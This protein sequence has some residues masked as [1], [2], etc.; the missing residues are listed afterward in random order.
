MASL[1]DSQ[2]AEVCDARLSLLPLRS[3]RKASVSTPSGNTCFVLH[4][5]PPD[6]IFE[7]MQA[8][9]SSADDDQKRMMEERVILTDYND[10]V[11]GSGSKTESALYKYLGGQRMPKKFGRVILRTQACTRFC[12]RISSLQRTS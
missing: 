9:L 4:V 11:I 3:F 5:A 7:N 12:S 2:A 10:K 1:S 8:L 6:R